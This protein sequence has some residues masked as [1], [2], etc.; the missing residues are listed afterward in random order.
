MSIHLSRPA[1]FSSHFVNRLNLITQTSRS[2][3]SDLLF[4]PTLA[5]NPSFCEITL[6]FYSLAMF[7]Y[8]STECDGLHNYSLFICH[9][10]FKAWTDQLILSKQCWQPIAS[11]IAEAKSTGILSKSPI[12]TAM[13]IMHCH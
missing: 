11:N 7:L 10:A 12:I 9:A 3:T 8:N 13:C 1:R 4:T 5:I 2:L 6:C